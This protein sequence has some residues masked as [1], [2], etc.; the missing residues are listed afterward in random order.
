MNLR[1]PLNTM[2]FNFV[3][4][5]GTNLL[6]G[7][8]IILFALMIINPQTIFKGA[9]N[10]LVLWSTTVLPG[11]FPA[12]IVSSLILSLVPMKDSYRYIY[13]SVCGLFCGFPLGAILCNRVHKK[14]PDEVI[15][16]KIMPYCNISSPSFMLNYILMLSCFEGIDTGIIIA[17]AYLPA[18]EA[19][20]IIFLLN[21]KH[22]KADEKSISNNKTCK[23]N[24]PLTFADIMDTALISSVKNGLKLGGY[25]TIFASLT[26][27]LNTII[28]TNV[29]VKA[30][31]GGI[32]EI[33]N[34][35]FM[36]NSLVIDNKIKIILV[37][38]INALGGISTL[39]QTV[40]MVRE[41]K[42]SIKKYIYHKLLLAA[43][44]AIHTMLAIYV[45]N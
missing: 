17:A 10:G 19:L 18:I 23:T 35:I 25:I 45:L 2:Q 12:M 32:I 31:L 9:L 15:C 8:L 27:L 11:L 36:I 37:L 28:H 13:I 6:T 4:L 34:G 3:R 41:S 26:G 38:T 16:E 33:T 24:A 5:S 21:Y 14:L 40:G 1:K 44:T 39:M 7:A 30:V 29:A 43:S 42:L 20:I 22:I